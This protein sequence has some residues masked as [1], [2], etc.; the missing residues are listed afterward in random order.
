MKTRT[1]F[2]FEE[3]PTT[4]TSEDFGY[5]LSKVPGTMF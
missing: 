5:I 2:K 1:D 4:M 3:A